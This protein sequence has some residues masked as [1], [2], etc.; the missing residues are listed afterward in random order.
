MGNLEQ[1]ARAVAAVAVAA[2]RAA[3]FEVRED[4]EGLDD[5]LVRGAALDVDDEAEAAGVVFERGIVEPLPRGQGPGGP[6]VCFH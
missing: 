2:R 1:Q 6:W 4:L 5:D 3:M